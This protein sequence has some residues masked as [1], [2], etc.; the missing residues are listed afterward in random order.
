MEK[1]P[2]VFLDVLLKQ[3]KNEGKFPKTF[4]YYKSKEVKD[5]TMRAQ[6]CYENF[7][8]RFRTHSRFERYS[9]NSDSLRGAIG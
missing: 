9:R 4:F 1:H 8:G 7:Q 3:K 5:K 2:L 6:L